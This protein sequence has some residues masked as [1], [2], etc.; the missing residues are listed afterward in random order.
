MKQTELLS[1]HSLG[2]M[3]RTAFLHGNNN[4]EF[5][6]NNSLFLISMPEEDTLHFQSLP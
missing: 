3:E 1:E 4:C 6:V 5:F 2:K